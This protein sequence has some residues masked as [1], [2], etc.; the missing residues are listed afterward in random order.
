MHIGS[1]EGTI[2]VQASIHPHYYFPRPYLSIMECF[3]CS[4]PPLY[5][6]LEDSQSLCSLHLRK[7]HLRH[8]FRQIP[9]GEIQHRIALLVQLEAAKETLSPQGL[10]RQF[11]L[12]AGKGVETAVNSF[13]ETFEAWIEV[14]RDRLVSLR[15]SAEQ[16]DGQVWPSGLQALLL[17]LAQDYAGP[18]LTFGVDLNPATVLVYPP[19]ICPVAP[20]TPTIPVET[21]SGDLLG[22]LNELLKPGKTVTY[23]QES[24]GSIS[25]DLLNVWDSQQF[26]TLSLRN[27]TQEADLLAL[28]LLL[29][30]STQTK[31]V[32]VTRCHYPVQALLCLCEALKRTPSGLKV[33]DISSN[34]LDDAGFQVLFEAISA[35]EVCILAVRDL[36]LTDSA[37][38][39]LSSLR[40]VKIDAVTNRFSLPGKVTLMALNPENKV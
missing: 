27:S 16:T 11:R 23:F 5:Q 7:D 10:K 39:L 21:Q 8:R 17:R 34:V 15:T 22:R 4:A 6:C 32:S 26:H 9:A 35:R 33:V 1:V 36:G 12:T 24:R 13:I 40:N 20:Q 18:L 19:D 37:L 31:V 29:F 14:H 28:S 38:P 30:R 25:A 3:H 2:G